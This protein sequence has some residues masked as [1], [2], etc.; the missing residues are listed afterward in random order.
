MVVILKK[1]YL[2]L[3]KTKV[4]FAWNTQ[5]LISVDRDL[6][7]REINNNIPDMNASNVYNA[8]TNY[9]TYVSCNVAS[10]PRY[11]ISISMAFK[12]CFVIRETKTENM[13]KKV[14]V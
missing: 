10:I 6:C 5:R 14:N 7:G 9:N 4:D 13:N 11:S 3:Y 12:F 2:Y 1:T 8:A